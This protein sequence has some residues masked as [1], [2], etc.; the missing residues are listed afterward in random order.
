M[1]L[2]I[3]YRLDG[4]FNSSFTVQCNERRTNDISLR[5]TQQDSTAPM[6]DRLSPQNSQL[7]QQ[8]GGRSMHVIKKGLLLKSNAVTTCLLTISFSRQQQ[9]FH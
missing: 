3:H 5:H 1:N 2:V 7:K 9:N 6:A 8:N 4:R